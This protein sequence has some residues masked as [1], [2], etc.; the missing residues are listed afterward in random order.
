MCVCLCIST[1]KGGNEAINWFFGSVYVSENNG[2]KYV[3]TDEKRECEAVW[4][5]TKGR[6]RHKRDGG[7][8]EEENISE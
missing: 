7:Q 5:H 6:K 4:V 8:V 3:K 2:L 1:D